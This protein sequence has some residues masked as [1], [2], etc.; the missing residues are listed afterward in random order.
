VR[1]KYHN[2]AIPM[3]VQRSDDAAA[4]AH[5]TLHFAD[6]RTEVIDM[7]H[8]DNSAIL[9]QVLA[10]TKAR[11]LRASPEDVRLGQELAEKEA[12]SAHVRGLMQAVQAA[13]KKEQDILTQARGEVEALR[14]ED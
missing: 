10:L 12:S 11:V 13:R 14:N 6:N 2:P 4:P 7:K 8:R 9:A 5:M 1:L 3:T